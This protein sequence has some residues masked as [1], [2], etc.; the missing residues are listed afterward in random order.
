MDRPRDLTQH[1]YVTGAATI[2]RSDLVAMLI[3]DPAGQGGGV[4]DGSRAGKDVNLPKD[5]L[6]PF[7]LVTADHVDDFMTIVDRD[8]VKEVAQRP[9]P[10]WA[11]LSSR[12]PVMK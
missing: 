7:T 1:G 6:V 5:F 4:G 2:N 9:W 12:E 10:N 8:S 3:K 11:H